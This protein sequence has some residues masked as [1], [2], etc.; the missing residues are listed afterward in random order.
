MPNP[1]N[2]K[3]KTSHLSIGVVCYPSVGGSGVM[4]TNLGVE[5]AKLGHQVHFISYEKPF[6]IN[7]KQK[8]ISFH[9]VNINKYGLFKYPD[10]TLPLAVTIGSVHE[11]YKLDLVHVHYAVPHATAALLACQMLELCGQNGLKI[12][13]TL[14]GTDITLLANDP[15]LFSIVK[16]S[17]ERSD[18]VTAV[19]KS[20]KNETL[21]ILK[22]KKPIEVIYNFYNPPSPAKS[23]DSIRQRLKI[24]D[25]D[26]LAIH[27][28]NL[29][30]VKRIPDLL[31]IAALMKPRK[32]FKLLIL[33]G[34][35]FD[36]Y[37]PLAKK[38]KLDNI[39]VRENIKDIQ[40]YLNAA[41]AGVYTSENESFGMGML[42][43]MSYQKPV[44]A[45]K[46]GGIPEVLDNGKSGY[47][48]KVGDINGFAKKLRMLEK[49]PKTAQKLGQKAKTRAASKFSAQ[50]IVRQYL[51]YYQKI[52][53]DC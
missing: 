15:N 28:S 14:H 18:G 43:T 31:K 50:K 23:R 12:I 38:L 26:F 24:K 19:S 46:V 1:Y 45:T 20:L 5:L 13:T 51:S 2:L 40:N 42:E 49:N 32:N 47:L 29:R 44:L 37:R 8:N 33:A 7:L 21:K 52:L 11:K 16:Y 25:S 39:I 41:D 34:E 10:Y 53:S 27:L 17:I 4:A 9:K 22:T 3:P 35:K 36:Q 6:R 48:L 30:P